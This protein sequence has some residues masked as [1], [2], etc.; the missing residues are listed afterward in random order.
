MLK[1]SLN[2]WIDKNSSGF[3]DPF[4]IESF[5]SEVWIKPD[6]KERFLNDINSFFC[7]PIS[8]NEFTFTRQLLGEV[9]M[10]KYFENFYIENM[11]S[12]ALLSLLPDKGDLNNLLKNYLNLPM[13]CC[14]V[15]Q[16]CSV[17]K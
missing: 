16:M 15:L 7:N 11:N 5:F 17:S 2:K 6:M 1:F 13:G 10:D 4:E 3:V 9:N 14:L 12:V 8:I